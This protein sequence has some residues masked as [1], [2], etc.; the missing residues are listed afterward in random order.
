M[1]AEEASHP[2]T[3][4]AHLFDLRKLAGNLGWLGF[5]QIVRMLVGLAINIVL[6][7]YLG[8]AQYGKFNYA[9]YLA[10]FAQFLALFQ[11]DRIVV[12]D[13]SQRPRHAGRILGTTCAL[14]LA[15]GAVG[16]AS[17]IALCAVLRPD[18]PEIVVLIAIMNLANFAQSVMTIDLWFQSRY[19]S[20]FTVTAKLLANIA[21]NLVKLPLILL[22]VPLWVLAAMFAAELITTAGLLAAMYH[23]RGGRFMTWS[24]DRAIAA[25]LLRQAGILMLAGIA[26]QIQAH[27]D[28]VI[29][30][31]LL[32]D[33]DIGLYS[34]ALRLVEAAN[35]VPMIT[36]TSVAPLLAAA[37]VASQRMFD[38]AL[39]AFYT[40]MSLLGW[41]VAIG[42]WFASDVIVALLY[43][44]AYAASGPLLALLGFRF[45]LTGFGIGRSLFLTNMHQL[46][47]IAL[48]AVI[49]MTANILL[50]LLLIPLYGAF[51]AVY[52]S[53]A[54]LVLKN[55]VVDLLWPSTRRNL[56]LMC[57]AL[58]M[59][60]PFRL[61]QLR[62]SLASA[63]QQ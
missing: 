33:N 27:A 26:T 49:G 40:A 58:V 19:Q 15:A 38:Q 12:R 22:G 48:I 51:G 17:T 21:V 11:L 8:P 62:R 36:V 56:R 50:N 29:M 6:V 47:L 59:P 14:R 45:L 18:D 4:Y 53:L 52:A 43:G 32:T 46:W 16:F 44:P 39:L 30:G 3:D 57:H 37:H 55:F 5:D 25:A 35:F 9:L 31:R 54:A 2:S 24:F 1:T 7:R 41:T 60:S 34:A 10:G 28:I 61:G 23:R 42:F 13:L 20:K 63:P